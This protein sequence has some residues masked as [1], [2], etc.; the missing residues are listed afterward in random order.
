MATLSPLA[1]R[2]ARARL[3]SFARPQWQSTTAVAVGLMAAI[4]VMPIPMDNVL[5]ALALVLA[6][7]ALVS[8]H[9]VAVVLALA[10]TGLALF[11]TV[12]VPLMAWA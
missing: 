11:F 10:T 8:R 3:S 7:P 1:G 5:P 12:G 2:H 9:E 6:G 4:V